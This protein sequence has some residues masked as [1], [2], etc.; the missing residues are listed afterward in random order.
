M[1]ITPLSI[2]RITNSRLLVLFAL[3][4]FAFLPV[5]AANLDDLGYTTTDGKVTITDC[6]EAATGELVIPPTI[7]GN[8]VTSIGEMAF[9]NCFTLTK[10]TLPDS[11]VSIGDS[12][13]LSCFSLM[14]I[15]IGSGITSIGESA[16]IDC[17]SL[18]EITFQGAAPTVGDDT[19]SGV[20]DGAVAYIT[21]EALSSFGDSGD[22]W[23]G[24]ILESRIPNDFPLTWSTDNGEVTITDCNEGATGELVIPPT[25][26]GNPVTGIGDSAFSGCMSL[27]NI[28]IPNSVTSI[29]DFAFQFCTSLT[30]I[31]IPN[32]VT[33]IGR[34]AFNQCIN[35][36]SITIPDGVTSI[37]LQAFQYCS[38]L[39][40]ITIGNGVSSIGGEAFKG[41]NSLT[42]ITIPNSVTSIG[43]SAF[44][45]CISLTSITIPDSVTSIGAEAFNR[46]TALTSITIGNGV[47]SIGAEAFNRCTSLASITIPDSVTS[48]GFL[49]FYECRSLKSITFQGVAPTVGARAFSDLV[50]GAEAFVTVEAL[51]SFGVVDADW[52]GLLIQVRDGTTNPEIRTAIEFS[53][54]SDEIKFS[55]D[56]VNGVN[57]RIE[58][59]TDL[60]NW[61]MIETAIIGEGIRI[62]RFYSTRDQ[63]NHHF[64]VKTN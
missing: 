51:S 27:T 53:F 23:N 36:T 13:F 28:T 7:E 39:T 58:A 41:C 60:I 21:A 35:L 16:F 47:T 14:I 57:Y 45:R 52:N 42:S 32:S 61:E 24:L 12:A 10:I 55:F 11:V 4:A 26:E 54:N 56:A 1:N 19:F 48:I 64:R 40:S 33:S 44:H 59:S 62:D 25:I 46:C 8:P 6:D 17:F 43:G 49:A 30:S 22:N 63:S 15:R 50:D 3:F 5:H 38:G 2:L 9:G 29:G 37:G 20:A 18:T 34:V 31:T